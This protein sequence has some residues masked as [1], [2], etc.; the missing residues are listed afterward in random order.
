TAML[1][2]AVVAVSPQQF[3]LAHQG[4][5]G[6][7][8]ERGGRPS[9]ALTA[10]AVLGL[11]AAHTPVSDRYVRAHEDELRT[12]TEIA[13]GVLA[14]GHPTTALLARLEAL[15]PGAS[16]NTAAWQ[17]LALAQAG[18]PLPAGTV[19]YLLAHQSR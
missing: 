8:A 14:E 9:A 10:W 7:F 4:R 12:P 13:L 11:R 1:A 5:D 6:A 16:L 17:L 15:Q 2:A 3:L 18:R 19:R